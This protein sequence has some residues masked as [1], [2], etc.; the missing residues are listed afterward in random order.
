MNSAKVAYLIDADSNN[1]Y[2]QNQF[3][4]DFD[5]IKKHYLKTQKSTLMQKSI[6]S[7]FLLCFANF[8]VYGQSNCPYSPL[9]FEEVSPIWQHLIID[10]TMIG[11]QAPDPKDNFQYNGHNHLS[12]EI[13]IN[14]FVEGGF[15]YGF[16][17]IAITGD[18]S[19]ALIEKIDLDTGELIWQIS[20][21]IRTSEFRE[22]V[23]RTRIQD[24]MFI[25]SGVRE[26]I[27]DEISITLD[28]N[29]FVG[30]SEGKIFER[31]YDLE[32]GI[33][34][35][36]FTPS[37]EDSL[38]YNFSFIPWLYY[39]YFFEESENFLDAKDFQT[40]MGRYLIRRKI[41]SLGRLDGG[42]D[43]VV[44]GR[45]NDRLLLDGIFTAGPRFHKKTDGNFLYIEQYSPIVGVNHSFEA[46][47]SEYDKDFNL[48]NERN[49]KDF[50]LEQFSL[51]Q[52]INV[53]ADF[54]ILRGC[55]NV[56]SQVVSNCE[57]FCLVL[58]QNLDLVDRF[59]LVDS[60]EIQ[61]T[62]QPKT[63]PKANDGSF[64]VSNSEFSFTDGSSFIDILQS[65]SGGILE[66]IKKLTVTEKN[67]ITS[68][69]YMEIL[70][71]GDFL[72]RFRHGCFE[73]GSIGNVYREWQRLDATDFNTSVST[74]NNA[75]D[76]KYNVSPNPFNIYLEID[77]P[78]TS[79]TEVNIIDLQGIL[80]KNHRVNRESTIHIN[81]SQI[82][83][84][85]YFI[86]LLTN[87]H[88]KLSAGIVKF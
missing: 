3:S 14:S 4:A 49:L 5:C 67:R 33:E 87:D 52:I 88:K 25:I 18:I 37:Q 19:G 85:Y 73:N 66:K 1:K 6:L 22:K 77:N 75:L 84:G 16:S 62:I 83:A 30:K 20:N 40:G 68:I 8:T 86:Q 7:I 12:L 74:N 9:E 17:E 57:S 61:Y 63:I 81:T 69:E 64:F 78:G 27:V 38:A 29:F 56:E 24:N 72:I 65:T 11:Y 76:V 53:E 59:D 32:T 79:I 2:N 42:L 35:S 13:D 70:E 71:N 54:I 80:I 21:D 46:F 39:N 15:L 45:F 26:D 48:I 23:L 36:H 82:E 41:D 10:S 28:E 60:E 34:I 58:D 43:T 31:R 51:L 44:T 47:L 55:Y 50:G